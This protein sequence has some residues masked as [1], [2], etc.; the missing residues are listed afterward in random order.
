[1]LELVAYNATA[2]QGIVA[3]CANDAIENGRL[4]SLRMAQPTKIHKS[5]LPSGLHC[6]PE[7]AEHRH[8]KQVDFVREL[9][10][11]KSTVSRWFAGM[12]P[13]EG[14]IV[15]IGA[16]LQL[17]DPRDVFRHPDDEWLGR[18]LKNRSMAERT[19]IRR[20]LEEVFPAKGRRG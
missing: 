3:F 2:C 11:D 9:N 4:L 6:I 8:L 18:L 1:M 12:L 19:R 20:L 15:R 16:F 14:N 5:K 17:E 7:W 10:V 13:D